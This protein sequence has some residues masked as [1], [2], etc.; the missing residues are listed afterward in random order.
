MDSFES[1]FQTA[2][3]QQR[4]ATIADAVVL[5]FLFVAL[6]A[7]VN[8][9][10]NFGHGPESAPQISL[11]PSALPVYTALSVA[12][13]LA[14]Y[15]LSML[16]T[17]FYGRLAAYN[18]KAEKILLPL[19]DVLQSVP[20]LSFLPVVLL[21]LSVVLPQ[22]LAVELASIVLI[23]TSQAWNLTFAWYQ[24]LTTIPKELRE[25]SAIFRLNNW[26]RFKSLELPFAAIPLIWNSMMSWAG[27]WFFLMAAEIFTV[28]QESFRLPGLGAYLQTAAIEGNLPA[29]GWGLLAL[30]LV[31][32]L[33][34]QLIWRP[35]LAW[36]DRFKIEMVEN[37]NPPTSWFYEMIRNARLVQWYRSKFSNPLLEKVD[38]FIN[39]KDQ[40][41]P[42]M[43][44]KITKQ[45]FSDYL[46][47]LIGFAVLIYGMYQ[48]TAYII[49]LPI[50]DW[51]SIGSGIFATAL[52]VFISLA[53]AMLWTIPLGYA[54]GSNPRLA[55]W[56]QPVVQVVASLPATALLPVLV[57][58][59]AA[60]YGGLNLSAVLLMLM[61][62]QWYLLFN[63]IAGAAAIPQDLK[64]TSALLGIKGWERW[65]TLILP[66][67]FPYIITGS[68]TASGG[69]WNASIVAE[70]LQFKGQTLSVQGI[71]AT[72]ATA[73]ANGNYPL[74]L[75]A[76]I[77]MILS[78]VLINRL[79]WRRL[80]RLAEDRYRME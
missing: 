72:I 70:Y 56:L 41:Q 59:L 10:V 28:G 57:V 37:D 21:S 34:D 18:K 27:G 55:K 77:C 45:S 1:L 79:L 68:I 14:A 48:T 30:T 20:I 54:I 25:A 38:K 61:G 32:I 50:Q 39:S 40:N 73:T 76:T 6:F 7:G 36:A 60:F 58:S 16:F 15:L 35:L 80:Y 9:A 47:I 2:G 65:R 62:T 19:L 52:R 17:I 24:S 3:P 13:M 63:I 69:A 23:F 49:R 46:L 4:K 51:L 33:M 78:V 12:R 8:L 31:I 43:D 22:R 75:T 64:Y 67:L 66:A 5:V 53:I 29:I 26:M 44:D 42:D 11:A 74:L 71:G